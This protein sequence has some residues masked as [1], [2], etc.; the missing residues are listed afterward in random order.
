M[1]A[2]NTS[3]LVAIFSLLLAMGTTSIGAILWYVQGEKKKYA[4]ERDFQHIRRNQESISDG[5]NI[6]AKDIDEKLDQINRD[7]L[8]I[9]ILLGIKKREN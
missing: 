7:I 6:I 9:K 2:F 3:D 8:E 5:L 1:K 4:S